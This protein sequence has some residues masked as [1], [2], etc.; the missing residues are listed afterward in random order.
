MRLAVQFST[1][2]VPSSELSS[3]IVNSCFNGAV[4]PQDNFSIVKQPKEA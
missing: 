4:V 1:G 3:A 2:H